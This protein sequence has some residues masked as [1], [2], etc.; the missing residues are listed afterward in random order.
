M[1]KIISVLTTVS[2][3]AADFKACV[4]AKYPARLGENC[5]NMTAGFF[6]PAR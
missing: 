4:K 1:K 3:D 2:K 5:L 6:F